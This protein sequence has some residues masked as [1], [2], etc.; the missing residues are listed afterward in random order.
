MT[1]DMRV[2]CCWQ[3]ACLMACPGSSQLHTSHGVLSYTVQLGCC[4]AVTVCLGMVCQTSCALQVCE[5][6]L[7][8]SSS[9]RAMQ[10]HRQQHSAGGGF[11]CRCRCGY[12]DS[13][14][15]SGDVSDTGRTQ[16]VLHKY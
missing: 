1:G 9:L 4:A 12:E 11:R 7:P 15:W 2:V 6:K 5:D 14:G 13:F 16:A 8:C 3:T 10:N